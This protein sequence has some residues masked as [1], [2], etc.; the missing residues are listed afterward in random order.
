MG[1]VIVGIAGGSASGKT[2]LARALAER[3]GERCVLLVHDRYYKS[4]PDHLRD[5]P[6]AHNFDTPESLDTELLVHDLDR[7]REGRPA[8]VPRYDFANHARAGGHDEVEPRPF[9][10]VEGILALAS[11]E[12]CDRM[13]YKVFVDAPP[14]VRLIR[15]IRRDMAR[16]GRDVHQIMEQ[17]ERTV[18][19]MHLRF[20]DPSRARADLVV[21][22]TQPLERSVRAVLDLIGASPPR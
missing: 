13:D 5:D 12:L 15:R 19:P 9:I 14:D 1:T 22:G 7:L 11:P 10:L 18:R 17:Y 4:L 16:R 3:L 21:D 2:S 20:V 6:L 8:E